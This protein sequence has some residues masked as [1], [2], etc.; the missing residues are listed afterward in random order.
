VCESWS[1]IL[2]EEHALRV[3][4]DRVLRRIFGRKKD[5][6]TGEW[7]R[8]HNEE[9]NDLYRSPNINRMIKSRRTGWAGHVARRGE[10]RGVYRVLVRRREGRRPL[11]SPRHRWEDNIK[12][13][14]QYVGWGGMDWIDLARERWRALVNAVMNRRGSIICWT[15]LGPVSFFGRTQLHGI[16]CMTCRVF[17]LSKF[18]QTLSLLTL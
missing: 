2:R 18:C 15:S 16:I 6:G 9:L 11:G 17:C 13:D 1:L 3:F 4:E 7:R 8:L 14:L 5:E 12:K 10:R